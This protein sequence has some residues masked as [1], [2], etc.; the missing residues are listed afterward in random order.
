LGNDLKAQTTIQDVDAE[1]FE[2]KKLV[3]P[4]A[5][6]NDRFG[7]ALAGAYVLSGWPQE[8]QASVGTAFIGSNGSRAIYLL[9][10]DFKLPL[11]DRLFLDH[12]LSFGRFGEIDLYTDG[13]PDFPDER[14]GSNDSDEDNFIEGTGSDHWLRFNFKYLLPVGFGKDK[15]ANT[16]FLDD[17]ILV[18]GGTGG[19]SWN[20]FKYG[21][22]YLEL[23]PFFR[24]QKVT[25]EERHYVRTTNGLEFALYHDNTDFFANPSEGSTQR[26]AVTRDSGDAFSDI[27][28]TFVEFEYSKYFSLGE[29]ET[30]KQRVLA[31]N[32]WTGNSPTW[33]E[34][35]MDGTEEVFNQPPSFAGA[36]LGG[37]DRMRGYPSARFYDQAVLYYAAELRLTPWSNPLGEISWLQPLEIDWWQFVPFVEVGRVAETWNLDELHTDM[38]WDVGLGVRAMAKHLVVRIDAAVGDEG[39]GIQMMVGHPF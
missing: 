25:A 24:R 23:K 9:G 13:N 5:F 38:K 21:R 35:E 39:G 33:D 10:R 1:E 8:Q 16:F 7:F 4:Y 34:S 32:I 2:V 20:P 27:S 19:D 11:G 6:Y 12:D 36:T 15:V 17:G 26:I 28:W 37:V 29:S 3:V 14:A 31:F 22:T 30:F 18:S